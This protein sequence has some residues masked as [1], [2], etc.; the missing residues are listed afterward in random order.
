[1]PLQFQRA[2]KH[3][4]IWSASRDGYSFV[5]SFASPTGPGFRGR[6]GFLASWRPLDLSKGAIKIGGSP[7]ETFGEAEKACNFILK[8]LTKTDARPHARKTGI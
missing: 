7:F 6:P 1:M 2:V 4:D 8:H 5:I 3:M